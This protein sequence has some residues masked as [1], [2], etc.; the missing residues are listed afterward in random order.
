MVKY[1]NVILKIPKKNK[2]FFCVI[3]FLSTFRFEKNLEMVVGIKTS[4]IFRENFPINFFLFPKSLLN[5]NFL[6][7]KI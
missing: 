6:I 2:N 5:G 7:E 3:L 1:K 4:H